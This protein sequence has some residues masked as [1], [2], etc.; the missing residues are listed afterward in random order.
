MLLQNYYTLEY[1]HA[2]P[3]AI[4]HFGKAATICA[5]KQEQFKKVFDNN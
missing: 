4:D 5:Q 3:S 2:R 1:V